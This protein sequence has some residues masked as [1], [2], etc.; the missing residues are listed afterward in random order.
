MLKKI[1]AHG[2]VAGVKMGSV[3]STSG[4]GAWET[5]GDCQFVSDCPQIPM[6]MQE[7]QPTSAAS[8]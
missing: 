3:G 8:M 1:E 6:L 4:Q 7:D 2:A 5:D